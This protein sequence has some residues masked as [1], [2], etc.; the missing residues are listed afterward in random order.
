MEAQ[1]HAVLIV[2]DDG[3]GKTFFIGSAGD[4]VF[5]ST[6]EGLSWLPASDGLS[7]LNIKLILSFKNKGVN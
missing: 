3:G 4:G 2:P 1:I 7:N 6:D 5:N